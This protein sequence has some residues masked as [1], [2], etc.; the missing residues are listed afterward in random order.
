MKGKGK[1]LFHGFDLV[2]LRRDREEEKER[3]RG[4]KRCGRQGLVFFKSWVFA[5]VLWGITVFQNVG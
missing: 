5:G 4:R 2:Q 3:E 1:G